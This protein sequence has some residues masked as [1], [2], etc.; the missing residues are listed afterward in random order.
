M[1]I[2]VIKH[3]LNNVRPG[4][5]MVARMFQIRQLE[6]GH[7]CADATGVLGVIPIARKHRVALR[8]FSRKLRYRPRDLPKP[9]ISCAQIK[10][11]QGRI[12]QGEESVGIL[13]GEMLL[14]P[15]LVI[16]VDL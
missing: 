4:L 11:V 9:G 5:A 8:C 12:V 13:V 7:D 15:R 3:A 1:P 6:T 16:D 10:M 2:K 14:H